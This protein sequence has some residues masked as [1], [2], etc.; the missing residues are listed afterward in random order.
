MVGRSIY[1]FKGLSSTIV[2]TGFLV[3][4]ILTLCALKTNFT[5]FYQENFFYVLIATLVLSVPLY[6]RGIRNMAT[7][8]AGDL[9]QFKDNK[10]G[11]LAQVVSFL[12]SEILPLCFQ[13]FSLVFGYIRR[14]NY[15]RLRDKENTKG[16]TTKDESPKDG[17][18]EKFKGDYPKKGGHEAQTPTNT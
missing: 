3:F 13:L 1:V 11:A 15:Y 16:E 7:G 14:K 8:I 2:A 6:V 17:G 10:A 12:T 4:G 5:K 9:P 18:Q